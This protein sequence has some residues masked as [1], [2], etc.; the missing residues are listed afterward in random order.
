MSRTMIAMQMP[1]TR[2]QNSVGGKRMSVKGMRSFVRSLYWRMTLAPL[3]T[4]P[5]AS[6][7]K[8]A[9]RISAK[10]SVAIAR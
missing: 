9:R 5:M 2:K 3:V 1:E 6:H 10:P 7:W 8:K 4:G